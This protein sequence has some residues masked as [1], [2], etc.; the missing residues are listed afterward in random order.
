[1]AY[2][3]LKRKRDGF[4]DAGGMSLAIWFAEDNSIRAEHNARPQIGK[5]IR[6]GSYNSRS[7]ISQDWWQTSTVIEIL[8][9][10]SERVVFKTQNSIY[11]WTCSDRGIIG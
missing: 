11:E 6:V 3:T 2:Y 8:L 5:C 9:D 4:G 7:Y 10:E 1:M